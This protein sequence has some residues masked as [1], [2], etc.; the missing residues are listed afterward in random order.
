MTIRQLTGDCREVLRTLPDGSVQAC[1]T[2][3]PYYGLRDYGTEPVVWGGDPEHAHEWQPSAS[4][5][6]IY[7][8]AATVHAD[9]STIGSKQH[10]AQMGRANALPGDECFCGAWLGSLGLEP[11]PELFIEHMVEV[12]RE[13]KRVLRDDGVAFVNLGDSYAGSGKGPS[14][15]N[16]IGDQE[17]RQGFA[18]AHYPEPAVPEVDGKAHDPQWDAWAAGFFDGEGHI[19]TAKNGRTLQLRVSCGQVIREPLERFQEMYGGS[20]W[21]QKS[22][23]SNWADAWIWQTQTGRA[24]DML[25]LMLPFLTVKRAQAELALEL[26]ATMQSHDGPRRVLTPEQIAKREDIAARIK[27]LNKVGP[28]PEPMSEP[29]SKDLMMIPFRV[30]LALQQDGWWI[31]SVMPWVKRSAMPES[32][33]DRPANAVEYVFML[34]KNARYFWDADAVRM[35]I[36]QGTQRIVDGDWTRNIRPKT[37]SSRIAGDTNVRSGKSYAASVNPAGRSFRNSD[38]FFQSWQGLLTDDEGEEPLALIVNPA[39]FSL[40]VPSV[41]R[42]PVSLDAIDGDTKRTASPTCPVHA[43]EDHSRPNGRGD[44]HAGSSAAQPRNPDSGAHRVLPLPFDSDTTLQHHDEDLLGRSSGSPDRPCSELANVH[45]SESHRTDHALSTTQPYSVSAQTGD[46]TQ[47]TST[48]RVPSG[49]DA[50][51][52]ANNTLAG[53]EQDGKA[54]RLSAETQ[55]RNADIC[56]CSYYR[57]YTEKTDHFATFPPKLVEPLIKAGTSERGCCA[58]CGAPWRRNVARTPMVIDR[59]ERTHEMGRT[60]S[61]G[62]M[63]QAPSSRTL[64]WEPTCTH[65][66]EPVPCTVLDPFGGSGTVGL[67]AD[68]LGRNAILIDLKP[69]YV[70]M[71]EQRLMNDAP[72]FL[73]LESA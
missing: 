21:K 28:R 35:D 29:K 13:V 22:R 23:N 8:E 7:S 46:H 24:A 40:S 30:A 53:C 2:S 69:S 58:E 62:T 12:F 72:L 19:G 31:R 6:R 17:R 9:T 11:N 59:S 60:R 54:T 18:G 14:G 5:R 55:P 65:A 45:N 39:P 44:A 43:S 34:T 32:V 51:T 47:R 49:S 66:G 16:G 25:R 3:P 71:Q 33:T 70:E 52:G 38:M 10:T 48:S 57:E 4:V 63:V 73:E 26:Q 68:R 64:G 20:L 56:T 27:A 36:S 41:R 42:V 50:H 67:V 15:H 37:D 61:S 1:V